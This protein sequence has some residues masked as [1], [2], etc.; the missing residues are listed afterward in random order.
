MGKVLIEK[1]EDCM[2]IYTYNKNVIFYREIKYKNL[3]YLCPKFS[4]V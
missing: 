2:F 4:Y 3:G 1:N